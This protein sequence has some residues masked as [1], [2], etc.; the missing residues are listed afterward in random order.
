[1]DAKAPHLIERFAVDSSTIKS[2]GYEDGVLVV[3][4]IS[5]HLYAY[6]LLAADFEAFA[7]AESK[8]RWFNANLKGRGTG[9]KLTGQCVQC[10]SAPEVIEIPC[11]ACGGT[12]RPI[13][14]KRK[15]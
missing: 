13:E 15:P 1:M 7:R 11:A 6:D 5:G 4:F 12:V 14:T 8:G 3:E 9:R 10:G 2:A